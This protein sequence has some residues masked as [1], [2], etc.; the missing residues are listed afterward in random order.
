MMRVRLAICRAAR[1]L[2]A[3]WANYMRTAVARRP[4]ENFDTDVVPS[5][6]GSKMKMMLGEEGEEE[7]LVDENGMPI[8][9]E[10][11]TG[12]A[13]HIP[14]HDDIE[15]E[16][17]DEAWIDQ[18]LGSVAIEEVDPPPVEPRNTGPQNGDGTTA[19]L[20]LYLYKLTRMRPGPIC[21]LQ[22][23]FLTHY[24]CTRT[25]P[26]RMVLPWSSGVER[27]LSSVFDKAAPAAADV[28]VELHSGLRQIEVAQFVP[29]PELAPFVTQFYHFRCDQKRGPRFP[30]CGFG[31]HLVFY[32]QGQG[33]VCGSKTV[34]F[35]MERSGCRFSAPAWRMPNSICR[36]VG[37]FRSG[38]VAAGLCR[39]DRQARNRLC[40]P[41]GRRGGN[42][43]GRSHNRNGKAFSRRARAGTLSVAPWLN[44]YRAFCCHF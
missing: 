8:E 13:G 3:A 5:P 24:R 19:A 35:I 28:G 1:P 42:L 6:N 39:A 29:P 9:G 36:S 20:K 10:P 4:V 2:L 7:I 43:F 17:L 16:P 25:V 27:C 21:A 26:R 11:L 34:R 31:P 12:D 38:A 18:A 41:Y 40:R 30:A 23:P 15:P 37:G 44:R 32:L 14:Q 33:T 22:S